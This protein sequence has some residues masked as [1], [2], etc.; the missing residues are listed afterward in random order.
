MIILK[1]NKHVDKRGVFKRIYCEKILKKMN[2]TFDIKQI[3][4]SFNPKRYTLRGLHYQSG[5]FAEDKII[6]CTK[7]EIFFVSI[8]IDKKSKSYLRYNAVVLNENDDK[9][10]MVDKNHATGFLTLKKNSELL[11][12]MSNYYKPEFAKGYFYKDKI[13]NIKWPKKPSVISKKDL[14]FKLL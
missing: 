11:Y 6:Y 3:N 2:K 1:F 13:L 12:L 10:I 14:S 7:G 4:V 8:D 5:K 9:I